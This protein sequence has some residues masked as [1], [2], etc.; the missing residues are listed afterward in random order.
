MTTPLF[1]AR[2]ARSLL[3]ALALFG[4][5]APLAA[6][7]TFHVDDSGGAD[8]LQITDALAAP[9]VQPG[10][11]LVIH[12]G[13]YAAFELTEQLTLV[14]PAGEQPQVNGTTRITSLT[15]ATVSGLDFV[16]LE[17]EGVLGKLLLH[18]V[19]VHDT[20]FGPPCVAAR[21]T[22]SAD[23][24]LDHSAFTG[25]DGTPFCESTG[26]RIESSQVTLTNCTLRGG[27]GWGDTFEGFDGR[28]A[29]EI[30][31]ASQVLMASSSAYG[32]HGGEP[33]VIFDGTGGDGVPA[34][35]VGDGA[36]L[37]VRGPASN[38]LVGGLGGF[39]GFPG[40]DAFTAVFGSGEL[41]VS[42]VSAS[43]DAFAGALDVT[44]PDPPQ[45]FLSLNGAA[46]PGGAVTL[47]AVGPE[48][49]T[50][51]LAGSL[52]PA[53]GSP[54]NVDGTLFLNPGASPILVMLATLGPD[55][56]VPVTLQVPNTTGLE[57]LTAVF[58]GFVPGHGLTAPVLA[59]NSAHLVVR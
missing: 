11:T 17:I 55:V 15:G 59:T 37:T 52:V 45:A 24:H 19:S 21:I 13:S 3:A 1:R 16:V 4:A 40:D 28:N 56:S 46:V 12:A 36:S 54:P 18:D 43:P 50:F 47:R 30:V 53:F 58:Q 57:G 34:V 41:V 7:D 49:S 39:G 44:E 10:D 27:S 25:K 5:L 35:L 38:E 31:G 20:T 23:V 6:A 14:A 51:W 2:A 26:L 22:S 29:L 33:D 42:G 9:A 32:G 8:F 48:S